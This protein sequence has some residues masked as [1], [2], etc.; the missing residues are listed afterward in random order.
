MRLSAFLAVLVV[1]GTLLVALRRFPVEPEEAEEGEAPVVDLSPDSGKVCVSIQGVHVDL[2]PGSYGLAELEGRGL[3][4]FTA[5]PKSGR[6]HYWTVRFNPEDELCAWL[7]FRRRG[8]DRQLLAPGGLAALGRFDVRKPPPSVTGFTTR[9]GLERVVVGPP[10][11]VDPRLLEGNVRVRSPPEGR[12]VSLPLG[13]RLAAADLRALELDVGDGRKLVSLYPGV[14]AKF[15]RDD[16]LRYQAE[17]PRGQELVV[18]FDSD[19][20]WT[21]V[22]GPRPPPGATTNLALWSEFPIVAMQARLVTQDA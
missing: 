20:P 14:P 12:W 1:L 6:T 13:Q 4:E 3:R 22:E 16:L 18:E 17:V 21:V 15:A 2:R 10:D 19:H 5:D 9:S 11:T 8:E 7:L